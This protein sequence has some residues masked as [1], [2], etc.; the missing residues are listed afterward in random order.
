M[1]RAAAAVKG[2]G[3]ARLVLGFLEVGKNGIPVPAR[4]IQPAVLHL[5]PRLGFEHPVH[6][7][8]HVSLGITER[9]VDPGVFVGRAG[10]EK[11][12]AVATGL[13]KAAGDGASGGSGAGD[14][15]V[16]G[17]RHGL[18]FPCGLVGGRVEDLVTGGNDGCGGRETRASLGSAETNIIMIRYLTIDA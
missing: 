16:I 3:A 11:K 8:V 18:G 14:D 15:E 13:G 1:K 12:D 4:E 10:F 2:V 5:R 6:R 9:D 7:G 17:I